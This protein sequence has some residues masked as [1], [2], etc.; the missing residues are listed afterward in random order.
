MIEN[1]QFQRLVLYD[2][3]SQCGYD[4]VAWENGKN[5]LGE[6]KDKTKKFDLILL[7]L[8]MSNLNNSEHV[9]FNTIMNDP[10]LKH[11]P[12]VGMGLDKMTEEFCKGI[13]VNFMQK[14]IKMRDC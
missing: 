11:I 6:L 9:D 8:N 5:A 7:D 4:V 12:I 10:N 14:P 2:F 3:L 13:G 1:D